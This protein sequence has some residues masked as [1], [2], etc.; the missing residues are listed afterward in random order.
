MRDVTLFRPLPRFSPT[1]SPLCDPPRGDSF[2]S[3]T[4][5]GD[6]VN[7]RHGFFIGDA[8]SPNHTTA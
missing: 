6:L 8:I 5:L 2:F 3:E 1:R 4:D 7:N